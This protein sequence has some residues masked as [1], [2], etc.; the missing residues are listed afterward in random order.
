MYIAVCR[1]NELRK[2]CRLWSCDHVFY[3]EPEWSNPMYTIAHH[4]PISV[5]GGLGNNS[6]E[7]LEVG[8]DGPGCLQE[9]SLVSHNNSLYVFGGEISFSNAAETP[10]WIYDIQVT[11]RIGRQLYIP[12][13]IR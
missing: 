1:I 10:L 9:H 7:E 12:K 5:A 3:R 4:I 6:W 11:T 2:A 13:Q 8:G